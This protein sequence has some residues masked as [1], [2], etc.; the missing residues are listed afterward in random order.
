MIL[1]SQE[2]RYDLPLDDLETIELTENFLHSDLEDG[3]EELPVIDEL[4]HG[5]MNILEAGFLSHF[6]FP[7]DDLLPLDVD[8][9]VFK[10][11]CDPFGYDY[12][13]PRPPCDECFKITRPA[14]FKILALGKDLKSMVFPH[15]SDYD[16]VYPAGLIITKV[17]PNLEIDNFHREIDLHIFQFVRDI[18]IRE[19]TFYFDIILKLKLHYD[20]VMRTL[21]DTFWPLIYS[22]LYFSEDHPEVQQIVHHVARY[23]IIALRIAIMRIKTILDSFKAVYSMHTRGQGLTPHEALIMTQ[24]EAKEYTYIP[25]ST[26]YQNANPDQKKNSFFSIGFC[27]THNH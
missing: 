9:N 15:H 8:E 17:P 7:K 16:I 26:N 14:L 10:H 1:P 6:D 5:N 22:S 23:R 2:H 13:L 19:N 24:L 3:G 27:C 4:L 18:V 20:E 21:N 25:L 11:V 12:T